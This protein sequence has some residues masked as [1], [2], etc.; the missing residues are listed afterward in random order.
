VGD[1]NGIRFWSTGYDFHY[2][3]GGEIGRDLTL[4]DTPTEDKTIN[5]NE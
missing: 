5:S 2:F 1:G 4:D 3:L